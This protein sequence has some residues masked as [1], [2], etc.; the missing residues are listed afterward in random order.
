[1]ASRVIFDSRECFS[2]TAL[3]Y[4]KT[5]QTLF[6]TCADVWGWSVSRLERGLRTINCGDFCEVT[7]NAN[8]QVVL[9]IPVGG[10]K[11]I[12][13]VSSGGVLAFFAFA[14]EPR[15][16]HRFQTSPRDRLIADVA[17]SVRAP[18]DPSQ[19]LLDGP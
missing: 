2:R 3:A 1:M 15:P 10:S 16:G 12:L 9:P 4:F 13:P 14:A 17:D 6:G 19:G 18:S 7:L 5:P 8:N 11:P